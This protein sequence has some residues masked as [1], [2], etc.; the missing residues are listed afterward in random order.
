MSS[1]ANL[2]I[3]DQ[4]DTLWQPTPID[5]NAIFQDAVLYGDTANLMRVENETFNR[6]LNRAKLYYDETTFCKDTAYANIA[7]GM[8]YH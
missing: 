3:P 7:K 8:K 4:D 6:S 2:D 5:V 1:F